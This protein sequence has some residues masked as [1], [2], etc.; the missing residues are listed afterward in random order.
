MLRSVTFPAEETYQP[1][2]IRRNFNGIF[3]LARRLRYLHVSL[4][5]SGLALANERSLLDP[6][7]H[8]QGERWPSGCRE[9]QRVSRLEDAESNDDPFE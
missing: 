5:G 9:K 3:D 8:R 6:L 2:R 7:N 1:R 4:A